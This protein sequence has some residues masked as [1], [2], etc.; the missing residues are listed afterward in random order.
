MLGQDT[1]LAIAMLRLASAL[2]GLRL[3]LFPFDPASQPHTHSP[4]LTV[5]AQW[6]MILSLS[7][8]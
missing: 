7:I 8:I 3:A 2:A 4:M 1:F 5:Q 6:S